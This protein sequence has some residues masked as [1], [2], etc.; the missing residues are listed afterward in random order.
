LS[1][2]WGVQ[3]HGRLREDGELGRRFGPHTAQLFARI[4]NDQPHPEMGCRS[5]LHIIHLA[6]QYPAQRVEAAA[7]RAR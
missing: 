6:Q 7:E 5:C 1:L 2:A 3:H 4:L